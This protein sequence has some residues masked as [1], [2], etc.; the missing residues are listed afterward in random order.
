MNSKSY[1]TATT[2]LTA[3][4]ALLFF[5]TTALHFLIA[6]LGSGG[7]DVQNEPI[8]GRRGVPAR[9]KYGQV[10]RTIRARDSSTRRDTAIEFKSIAIGKLLSGLRSRVKMGARKTE[11]GRAH[12]VG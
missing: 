6:L 7:G 8:G 2:V 5:S 10:N 11:D 1:L 9:Q 3:N 12:P 4:S